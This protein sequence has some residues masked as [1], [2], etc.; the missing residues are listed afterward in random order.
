MI[1]SDCLGRYKQKTLMKKRTNV[2]ENLLRDFCSVHARF[3]V[4]QSINLDSDV[5]AVSSSLNVL[6]ALTR[7]E[8]FP[9]QIYEANI[10]S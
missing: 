9:T 8:T 7:S 6:S 1:I 3:V 4:V 10:L 5:Y 2:V